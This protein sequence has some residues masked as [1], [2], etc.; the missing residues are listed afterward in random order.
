MEKPK[1]PGA[2]YKPEYAENYHRLPRYERDLMRYFDW[3]DYKDI[4]DNSDYYFKHT[5]VI[6]FDLIN[7]Q[8]RRGPLKKNR[9]K[10]QDNF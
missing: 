3:L 1:F 9:K 5:K 8:C 6:N 10:T 2:K 4:S 7:H